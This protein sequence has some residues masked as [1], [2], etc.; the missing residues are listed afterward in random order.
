[1]S[2]QLGLL[3]NDKDNNEVKTTG[4]VQIF[5]SFILWLRKIS[6]GRS[7]DE[8]CATILRLKWDS[9]P[10][11]DFGRIVQHDR[12]GERKKEATSERK[13]W[14]ISSRQSQVEGR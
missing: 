6:A 13:G 4:C 7:P 9:L 12:K 8:G 5:F 1:M 10:P 11:N 14:A 3:A 2:G